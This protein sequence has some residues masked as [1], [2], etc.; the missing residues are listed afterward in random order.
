[1]SG[2]SAS[3]VEVCAVVAAGSLVAARAVGGVAGTVLA[4]PGA[5]LSAVG[6]RMEQGYARHRDRQ[7]ALAEW[8]AAAR[9]VVDR[10]ARLAVLVARRGAAPGLPA[11]LDL[12]GQSREQLTA[13]CVATDQA[14]ANAERALLAEAA[15]AVSGLLDTVTTGEP[16]DAAG[17]LAAHQAAGSAP[18]AELVAACR[19]ILGGLRA[20]AD[21][22]QVLAAVARVRECA[23]PADRQGW[24]AE[25]R[26]RVREA[27]AAAAQRQQQA[28]TAATMLQALAGSSPS[29]SAP[30]TTRLQTELADVVAGRRVLDAELHR[31]AMAAC[32][33]VRLEQEAGYVRDSLTRGLEKLGYQVDQGFD[34]F[35]GDGARLRLVR[36]QWP[37]HAVSMVVEDGEVR[38]MV[39]R[40]ESAEGDDGVRLDVEREQQWCADFDELRD[41]LAGDGLRLDVQ[42]LTAPGERQ[43]PVAARRRRPAAQH[44][45]RQRQQGRPKR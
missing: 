6:R 19:R 14:L 32:E 12:R 18:P 3:V 1:M 7:A 5:G 24:L 15:A 40:T 8:E 27:N 29:R 2:E 22:A 30:V 35:T 4:A 37:E 41:E 28:R 25:L 11:P 31:Q 38:A 10:N 17:A 39:V 43:V 13:W 34:T 20:D 44:Q 9:E 21:R 45:E 33:Q 36:D 26:V 23:T 42:R 16:T